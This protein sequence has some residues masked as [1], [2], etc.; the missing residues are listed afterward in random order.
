MNAKQLQQ[1]AVDQVQKAIAD[2]GPPEPRVVHCFAE[3]E[4]N[5]IL[6]RN[7][8]DHRLNVLGRGADIVVFFDRQG[9]EIG[10]RD[11]GRRGTPRPQLAERES[12]RLSV[13]AELE[14]PLDSRLGEFT[15]Q[16]LSP[17][18]WTL[19]A[20]L[21]PRPTASADEIIHVWAEPDSMRIIQCVAGPLEPHREGDPK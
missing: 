5:S 20:V 16:E 4:W 15:P 12:F 8:S 2:G 1:N 11:D 17:L 7:M 9:R 10:W 21:I 6:L 19:Y 18:G 13:V 3:T 14:L